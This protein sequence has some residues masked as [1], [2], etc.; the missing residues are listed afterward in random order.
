VT[1][2][3]VLTLQRAG[4]AIAGIV[5]EDLALHTCP[6]LAKAM[7]LR[8]GFPIYKNSS[9]NAIL[10]DRRVE[11]VELVTPESTNPV[12]IEC[13]TVV[14]TGRFRP[15]TPLIDNTHVEQDAST[16][17]PVVDMNLMTSVQ[18]IFAA[19][20]LLRGAEMH[21]LCA[22]EGRHAAK[23]ILRTLVS[24]EDESD[25]GIPIRVEQ[26]IRYVA[27]QKINPERAENM[28]PSWFCPGFSIQTARTLKKPVLEVWSG[29][30]KIWEKRYSRLI[31]NSRIPLPVNRIPWRHVDQ[32]RGVTLKIK[33]KDF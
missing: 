19:G 12:D 31:A 29:N 27:P 7:G 13:D 28:R 33:E 2:S 32:E 16:L 22:L 8:F 25:D 26:P 5:E 17:G 3:A 30:R 18:N 23:G 15:Y 1:L 20:N 21:D 4:T 6:S 24:R 14:I 10:G 11:R 9:V